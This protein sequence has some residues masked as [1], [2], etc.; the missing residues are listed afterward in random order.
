M[1]KNA[2]LAVSEF[3]VRGPDR[4]NVVPHRFTTVLQESRLVQLPKRAVLLLMMILK[5]DNYLKY[6]R[7]SLLIMYII[8]PN[9]DDFR[10]SSQNI[11]SD[12]AEPHVVGLTEV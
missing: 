12:A 6:K 8:K 2:A 11:F 10:H 4:L 3:Q 1:S 5:Y 7:M 9:I